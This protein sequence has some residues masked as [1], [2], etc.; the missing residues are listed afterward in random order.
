M[1]FASILQLAVT[2]CLIITMM[3]QQV[4]GCSLLSQTLSPPQTTASCC[5]QG[6]APNATC[7]GCGCCELN[8][9]EEFCSCCTDSEMV[10]PEPAPH[11][12]CSADNGKANL[13]ADDF[14]RTGSPRSSYGSTGRNRCTCI[15]NSRLPNP[16][17]SSSPRSVRERQVK[18][19]IEFR[20]PLAG[21]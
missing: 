7:P 2:A 6:P 17:D 20:V 15:R 9:S 11:D 14:D 10:E 8:R 18:R 13:V 1:H 5:L 21:P 19:A 3:T 12:C 4:V 16:A